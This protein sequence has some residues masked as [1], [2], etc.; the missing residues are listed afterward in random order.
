MKSL[1]AK[2][3]AQGAGGLIFFAALIYLSAGTLDYWQGWTFLGV[4]T[5]LTVGF[6]IYLIRYDRPLLERRMNA[7]PW[8]EKEP[9]QKIIVSLIILS[10]FAFIV[11]AVLDH[12]FGLSPVPAWASMLG[13]AVLALSFAFIFWVTKVNSF[14]AAN[15]AVTSDQKVIS[16]GP[17]A[18]VRHPMYAGALLLF[19]AIPLALGS[20]WTIGFV[21]I[22][23]PILMWRLLDEERILKRE[24]PGYAEYMQKVK[25]RLVPHMW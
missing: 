14:A 20:W 13:E 23:I 1:V 19:V 18:H 5:A 4:F 6:T 3:I 15:I 9:S 21:V 25:Y 11:L 10:F 12:R 2:A 22:L 24:L 8:K 16:S 17:Y 7:G